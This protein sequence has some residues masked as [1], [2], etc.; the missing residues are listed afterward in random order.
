MDHVVPCVVRID[1]CPSL[2]DTAGN[3]TLLANR[4]EQCEC[5]SEWRLAPFG[6]FSRRNSSD[7]AAEIESGLNGEPSGLPNIRSRSDR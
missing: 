1:P 2:A 4:G 3:G 6:S 5:L 7:T